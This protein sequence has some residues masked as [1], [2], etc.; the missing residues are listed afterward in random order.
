VTVVD[1]GL[2]PVDDVLQAL[3]QGRTL[4]KGIDRGPAATARYVSKCVGEWLLRGMRRI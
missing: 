1:G 4:T 2:L 3:G